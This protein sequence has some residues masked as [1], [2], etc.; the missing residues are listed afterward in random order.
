[1]PGG[2]RGLGDVY[3][4]QV[5][6]TGKWALILA[7]GAASVWLWNF[8]KNDPQAAAAAGLTPQEME[9][10]NQLNTQMNQLIP[11]EEVYNALPYDVQKKAV[12]INGRRQKFNLWVKKKIDQQAGQPP[13]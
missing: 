7:V 6:A 2:S 8:V 3:K 11:T 13:K 12:E 5:K 4:R 10:W 1:L 9:E